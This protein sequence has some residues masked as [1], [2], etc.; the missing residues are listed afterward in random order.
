MFHQNVADHYPTL[1][2]WSVNDLDQTDAQCKFRLPGYPNIEVK[3]RNKYGGGVMIQVHESVTINKTL[4]T[5]F[6]DAICAEISSQSYTFQT[7]VI[8]VNDLDQTDAQCKFRNTKSIHDE[9][10]RQ[11]FLHELQELQEFKSNNK[12]KWLTNSWNN[13]KTKRKKAHRKWNFNPNKTDYLVNFKFQRK[14]SKKHTKNQKNLQC[15]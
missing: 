6:E 13:L 8:Y 15:R 10:R 9:S 7:L 2:S 3:N 14:N 1:A 5:P 11:L 4:Q 12:P